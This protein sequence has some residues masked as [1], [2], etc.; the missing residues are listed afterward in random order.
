MVTSFHFKL[1]KAINQARIY[2]SFHM[3]DSTRAFSRVTQIQNREHFIIMTSLINA[4]ILKTLSSQM[5]KS[6][7]G[8]ESSEESEPAQDEKRFGYALELPYSK[9]NFNFKSRVTRIG[10]DLI[11]IGVIVCLLR[12]GYVSQWIASYMTQ[13]KEVSHV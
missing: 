1:I 2:S 5:E 13:T 12:T 8:E 4:P 11:L 9:Q 3:R 10:R 7:V 6:M